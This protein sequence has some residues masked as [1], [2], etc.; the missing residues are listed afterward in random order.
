MNELTYKFLKCFIFSGDEI[1]F[2]ICN[3]NLIALEGNERQG[4]IENYHILKSLHRGIS[5]Q[6]GELE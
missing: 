2:I 6:S 1:E 3:S 5:K 4:R